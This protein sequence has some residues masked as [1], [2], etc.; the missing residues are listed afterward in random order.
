MDLYIKVP[1]IGSKSHTFDRPVQGI[2]PQLLC[3]T[4]A[5]PR[6]E[7]YVHLNGPQFH[8]W[9][10]MWLTDLGKAPLMAIDWST[11]EVLINPG[12]G[13]CSF[14]D[15]W[16]ARGSAPGLS[17][18]YK[19]HTDLFR[20]RCGWSHVL[21]DPW[22]G[23]PPMEITIWLLC[24]RKLQQNLLDFAG[25]LL[26]RFTWTFRTCT[27]A[28]R[29]RASAA[30]VCSCSVFFFSRGAGVIGYG[31]PSYKGFVPKTTSFVVP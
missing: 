20:L 18:R 29:R 26:V 3:D 7:R 23:Y 17:L 5:W 27:D 1:W 10:N 15:S 19:V 2:F 16:C 30:R 11:R 8:R 25:E 9:I 28:V 22:S 13:W 14:G 21:G 4:S 31:S 12:F 6:P 24:S